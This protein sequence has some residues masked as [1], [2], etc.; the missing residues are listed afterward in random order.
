MLSEDDAK[1][2]KK[3]YLMPK[4]AWYSLLALFPTGA[5]CILLVMID[6]IALG[7]SGMGTAQITAVIAVMVAEGAIT[8][9]CALGAKSALNSERWR[10][11]ERASLPGTAQDPPSA[12]DVYAGMGL[13]GVM[14]HLG[15]SAAMVAQAN[16]LA[17]PRPGRT[18]A[19]ALLV[20]ALLM[21]LAFIPRFADSAAQSSSTQKSAAQTLSA[22]QTALEP[23][24][25]YV[26]ADD[27]L[28]RRQDNYRASGNVTGQDGDIV[29]RV[30]I[31]TDQA[32]AISGVVY[33][34]KVDI[35]KTPQE[36]LAF[37]DEHFKRFHQLIHDIEAPQTAAGLLNSPQLP[38]EYCEAFLAGDY[39][40]PLDVDLDNTG[41]LRA[42]AAFTTDPREEFDEYSAPQISI[43]LQAT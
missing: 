23:G 15:T 16:N 31:T 34:A 21:V 28:E 17:L 19:I 20:P 40:T 36:N 38:A 11:L 37:A 4:I 39:Y 12:R 24:V 25:S 33:S 5:I 8:I 29:A 30:A 26:M 18:L 1:L 3:N 14:N 43:F 42:W 41:D 2:V 35:E 6:N 7:S 22:L 10:A 13:F 9:G 27:P 32:G